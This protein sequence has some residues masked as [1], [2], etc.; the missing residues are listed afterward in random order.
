MIGGGYNGLACAAYL[1]KP[2][3]DVLVVE[4]RGVLGG[5]AV[6]EE[7]WRGYRISSAAYGVSLMSAP[8]APRSFLGPKAESQAIFPMP[9]RYV[10]SLTR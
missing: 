4:R 2:G 6:T 10:L 9:I 8:R 7:P 5:A 1:A 3:M